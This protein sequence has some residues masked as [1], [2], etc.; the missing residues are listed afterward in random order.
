[1]SGYSIHISNGKVI[2]DSAFYLLANDMLSKESKRLCN[3]T[4]VLEKDSAQKR[5]IS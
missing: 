1:M 2:G 3:F 5:S 4:D